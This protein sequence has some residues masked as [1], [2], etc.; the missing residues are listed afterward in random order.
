MIMQQIIECI[1]V[2]TMLKEYNFS[3]IKIKCL[4]MSSLI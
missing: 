1:I 4:V 2:F 3:V